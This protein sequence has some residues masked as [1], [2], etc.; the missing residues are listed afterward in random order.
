[1]T[2]IIKRTNKK[3]P[4]VLKNTFSSYDEARSAIKRWLTSRFKQG[5]MIK[6][7]MEYNT[8]TW[9]IGQHGFSVVRSSERALLQS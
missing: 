9:F 2:Y 1:M 7:S 4:K 5:A 6:G 8:R 3:L